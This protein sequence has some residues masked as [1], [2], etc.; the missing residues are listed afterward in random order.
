MRGYFLFTTALTKGRAFDAG[1]K[2]ITVYYNSIVQE[3]RD[4]HPVDKIICPPHLGDA[5]IP[6]VKRAESPKAQIKK[7]VRRVT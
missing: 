3:F 7:L 4:G 5:H 6:F 1:Q 2:H